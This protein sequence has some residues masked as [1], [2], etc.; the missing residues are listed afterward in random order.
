MQEARSESLVPL[1]VLR[2]GKVDRRDSGKLSCC[3]KIA[4][5]RVHV[6]RRVHQ[7]VVERGGK[8]SASDEHG[9]GADQ[10]DVVRWNIAAEVDGPFRQRELRDVGHAPHVRIRALE[11]H[12]LQ[13][14]IPECVMDGGVLRPAHVRHRIDLAVRQR[15]L[16]FL[17]ADGTQRGVV[18]GD[19]A[20]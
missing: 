14:R 12:E 3:F 13:V 7:Q 16:R 17:A 8:S 20:H 2:N 9:G 1:G 11:A 4:F 19:T 6:A 15:P 5:P 10:G 18:R